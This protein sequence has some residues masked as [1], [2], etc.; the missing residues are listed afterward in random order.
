MYACQKLYTKAE[1]LICQ[2]LEIRKRQLGIDNLDVAQSL[3]NLALFY[4]DQGQYN[5]D[6]GQYNKAKLY[7]LQS[8]RI[9]KSQLGVEHSDVAQSYYNFAFLYEAQ[10]KY[11]KAKKLFNKALAIYKKELG[12]EHP[13]TQNA[14]VMVKVLYI[15][16]LLQCNKDT[17]FSI[18]EALAEQANLPELNTETM[19]AL[20]EQIENNPDLLSSIRESLQQQTEASDDDT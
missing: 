17:L 20:L 15:M 6:Q 10:N 1:F 5:K 19:L 13:N 8:L 18:L 16:E 11:K 4:K 2:S 12:N 3:H 7:Y 9:R 14:A